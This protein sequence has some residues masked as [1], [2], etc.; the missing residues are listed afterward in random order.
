M[1]R[2]TLLSAAALLPLAT[3]CGG[4]TAPAAGPTPGGGAPFTFA[5]AGYEPLTVRLDRPAQRVVTDIYTAAALQPYG[6]TPVGVWGYGHNDAGRGD[7]DLS[8][9]NVLGLD[10]EL[11]LEKLAAARPDIIVGVGNA[12]GTGW[13]WWDEKVQAQATRIAPFVPIQMTNRLPDERIVEYGRLAEALGASTE[14][15]QVRE[16]RA[17]FDAALGRVR[18]V[19]ARRTD[20]TVLA[21]SAEADKVYTSDKLGVIQM[22]TR[23]GVRFVGPTPPADKAWA[24]SSWE[25][26]GEFPSDVVLLANFRGDVREQPLYRRLPAVAAGQTGT[27]D[28]KRAY[29][30]HG[31]AAW[32]NELADVLDRAK[33]IVS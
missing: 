30:W 27:W 3:A 29:T 16:G 22:L 7:L 10:A 1:N 14:Q 23:A 12:A 15:P 21:I 17:A 11:S 9:L 26:I 2:R 19:A 5:P 20:L 28:D 24:T 33:N 13:T 31:Y 25:T 8:R 6:I 4:G 32:L 18:E